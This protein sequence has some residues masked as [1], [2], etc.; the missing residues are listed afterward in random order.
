MISFWDSYHGS[1]Y[2]SV[3][4][5]GSARNR[6][7]PGLTV[8][9]EFKHIPSPY[10]YRCV[11]HHEYPEC[12]LTCCDY[13]QY[14]IEKEGEKSVAAF[15]AEPICSWAGQVVPP[16][17]YWSKVK[18][19]CDKTG[20]LLI[21]DEVMTGFARTGKMF[22]CEH[23]NVVPD[24]ITFAKGISAGYVPLG[25][26]VASKKIGEYFDEKGFAHSYTYS[27]HA[28]AC[29]TGLAVIDY[30]RKEKLVDRTAKMGSYMIDELKGMQER[31]PIIGD[32]RGLGLFMG[33]ELVADP[34]TK[35]EIVPKDLTPQQKLDPNINPMVY[36]TDKAKEKGLIIG[37]S[38]GT[39]IIR[40]MPYLIITKE[41]VDEGLKI[42]EETIKDTAKRFDLPKKQ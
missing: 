26:T 10:C 4:V 28:L 29:A 5:G 32:V 12:N 11:F 33:I 8:F 9:E 2:A 42:L 19:I 39:G 16:P 3:S 1:T 6:Q 24:I 30:Y 18:K 20:I 25:A 34:K 23:W 17:D 27:G 7:I 15:L 36:L 14:T 37:S 21:F 38:P 22:A 41:Q 31:Q 40:M 13:L 35:E